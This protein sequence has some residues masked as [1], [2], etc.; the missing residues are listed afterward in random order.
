M[1]IEIRRLYR[2]VLDALDLDVLEVFP[3]TPEIADSGAANF[4][5]TT[6][7]VVKPLPPLIWDDTASSSFQ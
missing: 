5:V 3:L 2:P 4:L 7:G 6:E 1:P